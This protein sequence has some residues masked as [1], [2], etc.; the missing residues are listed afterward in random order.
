MGIVARQASRT[1]ALPVLA[2]WGGA[3]RLTLRGDESKRKEYDC[4]MRH[5]LADGRAEYFYR[6]DGGHLL[7]E[8]STREAALRAIS[9]WLDA[10]T[11]RARIHPH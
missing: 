5:E 10:Q 4:Y 9:R 2:M 11:V 8:G 3:D 1:L 6:A 7:T